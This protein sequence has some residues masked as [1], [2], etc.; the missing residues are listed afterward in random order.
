MAVNQWT[1]EPGRQVHHARG[2]PL[3]V[4]RLRHHLAPDTP[5]PPVTATARQQ[6]SYAIF[7]YYFHNQYSIWAKTLGRIRGHSGARAVKILCI[8][9]N[10]Q[11]VEI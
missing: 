9:W 8:Q 2:C 11:G 6:K 5:P 10:V 4:P 1:L 3:A 7:A